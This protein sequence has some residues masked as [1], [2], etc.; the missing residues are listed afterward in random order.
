[1]YTICSTYKHK[2]SMKHFSAKVIL[3]HAIA[4]TTIVLRY[5][6]IVGT[7]IFLGSIY[8][9]ILVSVYIFMCS[10]FY[11]KYSTFKYSTGNITITDNIGK[12]VKKS[13][14]LEY[15]YRYIMMMKSPQ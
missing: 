14:F 9:S 7:T 3:N 11:H 1:M 2:K 13:E 5:Q 15:V 10:D 4:I 12:T 6:H 8:S